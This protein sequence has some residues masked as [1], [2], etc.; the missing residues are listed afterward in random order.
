MNYG[1]FVAGVTG[2]RDNH[3]TL[4]SGNMALANSSIQAI[5]GQGNAQSIGNEQ[6]LFNLIQEVSALKAE[7]AQL[8]LQLQDKRLRRSTVK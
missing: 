7:L 6:R 5:T 8:R 4:N 1:N 3:I 2:G